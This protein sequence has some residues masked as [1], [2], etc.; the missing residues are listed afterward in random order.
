[1]RYKAFESSIK[2]AIDTCY[3]EGEFRYVDRW[4]GVRLTIDVVGQMW[5]HAADAA[6]RAVAHHVTTTADYIEKVGAAAPVVIA[7][8]AWAPALVTGDYDC[9]A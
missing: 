2:T 5:P 9:V 7:Q 8:P 6:A 1:M 4:Y 3:R